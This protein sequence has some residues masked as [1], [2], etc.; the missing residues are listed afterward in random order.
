MLNMKKLFLLLAILLALPLS[1]QQKLKVACVGNSVTYGYLLPDREK[2]AY[3]ARLQALLGDKAEVA[4]FGHSGA[5]LLRKG[6]R[7]YM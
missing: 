5:T 4:N 6:H 2:N 1:A 3:P 7:P